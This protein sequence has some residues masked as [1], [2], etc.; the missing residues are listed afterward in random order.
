L[1]QLQSYDTT[2]VS[3]SP[4]S[5]TVGQAFTVTTKGVPCHVTI[6]VVGTNIP[7]GFSSAGNPTATITVQ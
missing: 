1:G 7:D 3:V 5:V 6:T 4:N 2:C